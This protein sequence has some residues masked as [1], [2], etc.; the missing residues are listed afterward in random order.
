M[1]NKLQDRGWVSR[2]RHLATS[3]ALA[4]PVVLVP[5]LFANQSAQAQTL[6]VLY[7]FTGGADGANP[8]AGL[9]RD[10]GGNLLDPR[11]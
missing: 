10:A 9:I 11:I 1:K 4:L 6:T 2:I 7:S 5:T 8:Y 3:V